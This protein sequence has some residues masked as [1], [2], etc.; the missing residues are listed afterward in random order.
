[1]I[2]FPYLRALALGADDAFGEYARLAHFLVPIYALSGILSLRILARAEL[3]R[4]FSPKQMVIGL[5]V[6]LAAF[7]AVYIVLFEA[8][9]GLVI[10]PAITCAL[11]IFFTWLL[12]L[13]GLRHA[14]IPLR[15]RESAHFVTEE[16][17]NKMKLTMYED[18]EDDSRLSVPAIVVLNALLLISLAWN[19]ATLPRAANDFDAEVRVVNRMRPA[20]SELS[21]STNVRLWAFEADNP[22]PVPQLLAPPA[23]SATH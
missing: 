16:E 12:L 5:A 4:S 18:G 8:N 14:E 3:F 22:L 1:L 13:A 7:G 23:A 17:R 2:A 9:S 10:S 19:L 11:L 6:A 21:R 20:Y 15:K